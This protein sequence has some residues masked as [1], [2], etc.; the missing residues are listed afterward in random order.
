[1]KHDRAL[2]LLLVPLNR[3]N[4]NNIH[5]LYRTG[6]IFV[7]FLVRR[8][9]LLPCGFRGVSTL[10]DVV[11][12]D[13][14]ENTQTIKEER[15]SDCHLPLSLSSWCYWGFQWCPQ[16]FTLFKLASLAHLGDLKTVKVKMV[17]NVTAPVLY[18][19]FWEVVPQWLLVCSS[20][21]YI[22]T[23]WFSIS[24]LYKY[25]IKA[26]F[27]FLQEALDIPSSPGFERLGHLFWPSPG[28]TSCDCLFSEVLDASP[29]SVIEILGLSS[30]SLCIAVVFAN[31]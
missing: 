10:T 26:T 28:I 17:Q 27:F 21:A 18:P 2:S 24:S 6:V 31:W 25:F 16:I 15:C 29:L 13:F 1:M 14:F 7:F 23:V 12:L 11:L 19:V 9:Y 8:Q 3:C 5:L 22:F 20:F 4:K 30:G